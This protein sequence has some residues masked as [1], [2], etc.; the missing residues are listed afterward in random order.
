MLAV[1]ACNCGSS[2]SIA[3]SFLQKIGYKDWLTIPVEKGKDRS[4]SALNYLPPA[5][6]KEELRNFLKNASKWVVIIGYD[7][8]TV[9]WADIAHNLPKSKI[10]AEFIVNEFA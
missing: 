8:A 4:L 6:E 2:D 9:R 10:D 5:Q 1:I 7:D 3:H